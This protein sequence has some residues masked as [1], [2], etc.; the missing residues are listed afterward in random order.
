MALVSVA[1]VAAPVTAG[2]AGPGAPG[3]G[4]PFFPLEGN[5]GYD[6]RDY[7][8]ALTWDPATTT[9][10]GTARI[11]AVATDPLTSFDLDLRGFDVSSVSVNRSAATFERDG[12]ELII[13]PAHPLRA[14][15]PFVV[16]VQY[17]GTP[18]VVVDPD[19]SWEGWIASNDGTVAL[20]EPQ[21]TPAWFPANDHPT[22]KATFSLAITVPG[23]L[24][25]VSNGKPARPTRRGDR[26]TYTWTEDKPMATYLATLS[27]GHFTMSVSRTSSGLPVINA[28]GPGLEADSAAALARIP[29]M[30]DWLRTIFGPYPF[31]STG[32]IVVDAPDV[33]Y[34]LETQDRPTFTWAPDDLTMVHELA[35]Q[36]V[37]NSVSVATWPEIWLN[38]GFAGYVEWMWT[39]HDGGPTA[40][41][42][43]ADNYNSIPADDPFW[44]LPI[45]PST[46]PDASELFAG[47]VYLRGAMTL[48]V[49]RTTIG[50]GPFFEVLRRWTTEHRYSTA[51]TADFIA[52]AERVSQQQLD[53]LFT[54][55]LDTPGK[56]ALV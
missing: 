3:V 7:H 50:D 45:G 17:A 30:I 38:E 34:A 11:T 6:V 35:H 22:D 9:L 8:L 26:T 5:G 16:V 56:P 53:D 37:G 29:E 1:T 51:S 41:E 54:T 55:W 21:G 43:F 24:V 33:G 25:A 32:A 23:D 40:D 48:H 20:G 52:L 44:Q 27:I 13:T 12:Q 49:L 42:S 31:S 15:R 36:W 46:L 19:G 47:Q 39:E 14:R 18:E 4:D 2:D 28:V 10:S